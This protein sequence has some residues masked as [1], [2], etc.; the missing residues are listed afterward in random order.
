MLKS[1]TNGSKFLLRLSIKSFAARG[2]RQ[3]A[4]PGGAASALPCL[5]YLVK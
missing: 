3:A 5:L 2:D 1:S 4:F